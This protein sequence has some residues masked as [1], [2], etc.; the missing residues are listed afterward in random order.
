VA[1]SLGRG[2]SEREWGDDEEDGREAYEETGGVFPAIR[3][4]RR[5]DR[6]VA[7]APEVPAGIYRFEYLARA[8]TAG[9]FS[10]PPAAVELMYDPE[11][12]ARTAPLRFTVVATKD[13]KE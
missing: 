9:S 6:V 4:E 11:V 2:L 13:A 3:V 5:D 1:R 7:F 8:A 12:R 10:A